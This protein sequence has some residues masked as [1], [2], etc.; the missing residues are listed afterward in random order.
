MFALKPISKGAV[1]DAL[2]KAHR[3]RLLNEP[4]QAQSICLDVLRVEPENQQALATLLLS[5]TDQFGGES[6]PAK[7]RE[8]LARMTGEYERHYY[9]GLICERAAHAAMK[10]RTPGAGHKAHGLLHEA[11]GHFEKAEG[12]RSAGHDDA[13]LRW[14]TCARVLM[15]LP[16]VKPMPIDADVV[17][18]D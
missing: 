3:Y 14:N 6:S 15:R 18:D 7:A 8:V 11:M 5:L 13:I 17:L 16:D 1:P 10:N 12:I 9:G 2:D 4:M